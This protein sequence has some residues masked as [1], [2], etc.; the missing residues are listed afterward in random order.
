MNLVPSITFLDPA[1]NSVERVSVY[2]AYEIAD[3]G[4]IL[5]TLRHYNTCHVQRWIIDTAENKVDIRLH[6]GDMICNHFD[7]TPVTVEQ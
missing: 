3:D 2:A 4:K 5:V 1:V 6:A 7:L